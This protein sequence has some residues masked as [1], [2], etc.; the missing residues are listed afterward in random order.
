MKRI[1]ILS[2]VVL[3]AVNLLAGVLLSAYVKFNVAVSSM[4]VV[5]TGILLCLTDSIGLKDAF[6]VALLLLFSGAGLFAFIL[7][8]IIPDRWTDNG[9]LMFIIGLTA[10]ETILL[11]IVH[12]VS[13]KIK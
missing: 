13:K 3:L 12:A 1:I 2:V 4:V 7:S 6:K 5:V 11:I 8:L 9:W 10:A